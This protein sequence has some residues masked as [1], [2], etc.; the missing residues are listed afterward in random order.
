[1][2]TG[3]GHC[4]SS[5]STNN[6]SSMSEIHCPGPMP[7]WRKCEWR[8][9]GTLAAKVSF[10]PRQT[11]VPQRTDA[12]ARTRQYSTKT[13]R[14]FEFVTTTAALRQ[15]KVIRSTRYRLH[16]QGHNVVN[17]AV[18]VESRESGALNAVWMFGIEGRAE[19]V[20][21]HKER[22][23]NVRAVQGQPGARAS[24]P[25]RVREAPRK[26]TR[27]GARRVCEILHRSRSFCVLDSTQVTAR[28]RLRM[29]GLN[30]AEPVTSVRTRAIENFIV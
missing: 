26:L 21:T 7:W 20:A 17:W 11:R 1:M 29:D 24:K 14:A 16:V 13:H 25:E 23:S 9:G 5:S 3:L 30:A 15:H 27:G 28:P 19:R 22:Y 12:R 18:C 8:R 4:S 2:A 10:R 6:P